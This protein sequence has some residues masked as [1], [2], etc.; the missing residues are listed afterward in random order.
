TRR[1]ASLSKPC[2]VVLGGGSRQ[3]SVRLALEAVEPDRSVVVCHD[4]ARPFAAPELFSAVIAALANAHGAVP[5]L[6]LAATVKRGRD[7]YV[8]STVARDEIR[9]AQTPQAFAAP[10]LR[11]VH[12]RAASVGGTGPF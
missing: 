5:V 1:V 4:A 2:R 3:E 7:G 12:A 9:L 11:E 10:V 8:E 6:P